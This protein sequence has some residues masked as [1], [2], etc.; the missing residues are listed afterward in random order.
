[1]AEKNQ[2][3]GNKKGYP[4]MM[5]I[6]QRFTAPR[7]VDLET[8]IHDELLRMDLPGKVRSGESVA[9]PVG[10]RGVGNIASIVKIL[11]TELRGYGLDPL[12]LPAMGSHGRGT[13]EGQREIIESY[14]VTEGFVG[15][16]IRSSMEVV[17]VGRT[18][19][20]VPVYF[21]KHAYEAD[22][23]I[24]VNRIKPHPEFF[25]PTESGLLKMLLIG[26]G[27]HKGA[28]AYHRVIT[29]FGFE[30]LIRTG[31]Q[32]V[33]KS[34]N[35]L[36]GLAIV[37]NQMHETALI[38]AIEPGRL[39][40]REPEL[41]AMSRKW[42]AQIPFADADLLI[43]N[44]MG[45]D[46]CGSG[47]D[48]NVVGRKRY[49]HKAADDETP[50]IRRIYVRDLTE[51]THGNAIGIGFAEFALSRAIE[52]M[53]RQA[54][55]INCITSDD[56][57]AGSIPIHF[58]TDREVLDAALSTIGRET[59]AEARVIWIRNTLALRQ[60]LVSEAYRE[61]VESRPD[62]SIVGEAKDLEFTPE[63][64]LVPAIDW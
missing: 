34:C 50:K 35:V 40:E 64:F 31:N 5:R 46:I 4:R 30:H 60:M 41:L 14:G 23:T 58:D 32:V 1:M 52:K 2:N 26:L 49:F 16:P 27:K 21:D 51:E 56:L 3:D 48:T 24:V 45:K 6:E 10:S 28:E 25:G 18:E 47:F 37:E 53:D 54:T 62:L 22:H 11:V 20:G 7:V 57:A 8:A 55:Y 29:H 17:E 15:A 42:M 38:E 33:L 19:D 63:G 36:F 61:E 43:V 44:E 13:A 12:I 9:I 59:P 39:F